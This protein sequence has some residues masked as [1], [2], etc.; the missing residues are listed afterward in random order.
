MSKR[1]LKIFNFFFVFVLKVE[2]TVPIFVKQT[3]I[4]NFLQCQKQNNLYFQL[5]KAA[6][7]TNISCLAKKKFNYSRSYLYLV[8]LEGLL[9]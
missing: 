1:F 5:F 9:I 4:Q 8:D 3:S 6:D 2:A 7:L